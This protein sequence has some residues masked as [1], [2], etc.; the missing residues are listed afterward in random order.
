MMQLRQQMGEVVDR[1]YYQWQQFRIIR[2]DKAMARLVNEE[3]MRAIED[4]ITADPAV[5][6]TLSLM[7]NDEAMRIIKQ[8]EQEWRAGERI[9]L[10]AALT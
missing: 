5:A 9:P 7:L 4:L 10:A 8:G 1:V 6:D 2:K 3:Y